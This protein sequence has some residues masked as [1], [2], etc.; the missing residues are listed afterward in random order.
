MQQPVLSIL[1]LPYYIISFRKGSSLKAR[2]CVPVL[3]HCSEGSTE[4][5]Q[6]LTRK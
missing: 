4:N 6:N 5:Q 2:F 3:S 1:M